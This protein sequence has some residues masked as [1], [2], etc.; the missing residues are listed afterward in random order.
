MAG[1][2]AE[3]QQHHPSTRG[4]PDH[5]GRPEQHQQRSEAEDRDPADRFDIPTTRPN[6]R[7]SSTASP[8]RAGRMGNGVAGMAYNDEGEISPRS[9]STWWSADFESE[10]ECF[11]VVAG[12][13]KLPAV[14]VLA[15]W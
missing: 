9:G 4:L 15:H 3:G 10:R 12:D 11:V 1:G 8:S 6:Q 14:Q 7:C 2:D 13:A 5:A